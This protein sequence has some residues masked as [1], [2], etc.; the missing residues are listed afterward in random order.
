MTR[1]E[2]WNK[3]P[4][5]AHFYPMPTAAYIEDSSAR[6][7]V[8]TKQS[9]GVASLKSGQ[10]EVISHVISLRFVLNKDYYYYYYYYLSNQ[11]IIII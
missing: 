1:R 10:L 7:T 3:L 6:I 5:Q 11:F 4:L 2:R 9:L 8:A